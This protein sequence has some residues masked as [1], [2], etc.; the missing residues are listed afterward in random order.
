MSDYRA[1]LS[2]RLAGKVS[3]DDDICRAYDHDLGEMPGVLLG[4]FRRRPSCVVL[5]K[6]AEDVREALRTASEHDIP[7]TPRGQ[8]SSGYG[9]AMPVRGGLVVDFA[10]MNRVL[11]VDA[12]HG[13]ADVEPGVVWTDLAER[14]AEDGLDLRLCPTSGP[15]STVGGW[16]AMGGSGIGSLMFGGIDQA[17]SEIDAVG[18][19]GELR[20]IS[21][22]EELA[23]WC[24]SA[25]IL[26]C[27]TRLRLVCRPLEPLRHAALHLHSAKDL[28]RLLEEAEGMAAYSG[29]L[30]SAGYLALQAE[31]AG[32]KAPVDA[33]FLLNLTFFERKY[34]RA[35]LEAL[36]L[37]HGARLLPDETA[38]HEWAE[39]FHPMRIKRGGPA[40][41]CGEI[42][43]PAK[44]FDR[45][46]ALATR[47]LGRDRIGFEA[48]CGRGGEMAVLVYIPDS[49]RDALSLFRMGKAMVPLHLAR[50][51][52][53]RVY[54]AGLWFNCQSA[55]VFG[56]EHYRRLLK[57]KRL[58]DPRNL[59][60]PGKI[61]GAGR[62]FAFCR[63]LSL[64]IWF[65]TLCALP[66]SM[67]LKARPVRLAPA[68][69]HAPAAA[70]VSIK[71]D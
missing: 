16:F 71:E 21:S 2:C 64:G 47:L 41:L 35:A 51:L 44:N 40:L 50:P 63:A 27:V 60:N 26:G 6:S 17:V 11:A 18:P 29:T 68:G 69:A 19:D 42:S 67:L 20:T 52:G 45:L 57:K 9:G 10:R 32:G 66:L 59:M 14:L 31:A 15:S 25:G 65:G 7:V 24:G 28:A 33:G 4:L 1:V 46:Q 58:D 55:R 49:N 70:N 38:G 5:P 8:A 34:D 3:A 53:G 54:S 48:F 36:A 23:L 39:R 13:F 22:R 61:C 62:H 12:E 30:L 43:L 37:R 56:R